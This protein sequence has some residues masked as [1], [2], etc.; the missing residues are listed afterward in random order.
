MA[1][2]TPRQR[3]FV[4]EYLVDGNGARAA[5]AAGY[6]RAGAKVTA[7]RL[8]HANPAVQAEIQ[9]RQAQDA[10]RLQIE[11][12]DVIQGL[13]EAIAEAKAQ[14]NP[15]AMISGWREIGRLLGLFAPQQHAVELLADLRVEQGR[16]EAMADTELFTLMTAGA[17]G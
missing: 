16:Y 2:L 1:Q 9:V 3:Q 17:T 15:A 12:Q 7:H 6:G 8:T 13:L 11:R 10:Q 5:V 14:R 4:A